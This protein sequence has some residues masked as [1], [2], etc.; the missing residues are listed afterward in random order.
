METS[1]LATAAESFKKDLTA[2]IENDDLATMKKFVLSYEALIQ[3]DYTQ[4]HSQLVSLKVDK[5]IATCKT[6]LRAWIDA[7][8]AGDL[9]EVFDNRG[10]KWHVAKIKSREGDEV[11]IHYN[12]WNDKFDQTLNVKEHH[13]GPCYLFTHPKKTPVKVKRPEVYIVE[14]VTSASSDAAATT[15]ESAV[16]EGVLL[17]KSGRRSR[18]AAPVS[19]PEPEPKKRKVTPKDEEEDDNDWIC[20]VCSMYESED[21][22]DL[23][24]CDGP[25]MRSF[26]KGCLENCTHTEEEDDWFC[27]E[28]INGAH[29][30]FVCGKVGEDYLV[31]FVEM[32]MI[33]SFFL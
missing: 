5:L 19:L 32:I 24:M 13:I 9:C 10:S 3:D 1:Q 31:S 2:A 11:D 15:T 29:S 22:S 7:L 28:C 16:E 20:S 23:L 26:H 14:E 8:K 21:G 18:G 6:K 12:G 4:F 17:T 30:C 33:V 27:D 25:C